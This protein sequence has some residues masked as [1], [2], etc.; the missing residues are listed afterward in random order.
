M[1]ADP[2]AAATLTSSVIPRG[3]RNCNPLN[4]RKTSI[5]WF[6]AADEQ[7]DPDFVVFTKPEYGIRAGARILK[8]YQRE[9]ITTLQEA[10][11]RW[12]PPSEN[13]T[14]SYVANVCRA[15]DVAP[16][17]TVDLTALLPTLIPA[18]IVQENGQNPYPSETINYGISLA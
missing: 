3:I 6:G 18:M 7:T 2:V 13:A 9:G 11:G 5:T 16:G 8:T 1:G 17:D 10:I 4:I 15:C 12:A 14:Q